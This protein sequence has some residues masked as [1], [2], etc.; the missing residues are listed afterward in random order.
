M[1][2]VGRTCV[3]TI[4]RSRQNVAIA[5]QVLNP[6]AIGGS[7]KAQRVTRHFGPPDDDTEGFITFRRRMMWK[8]MGLYGLIVLGTILI[9]MGKLNGILKLK[10]NI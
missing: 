10:T 7:L 2:T 5:T 3:N 4:R 9:L 8:K 1:E 6:S